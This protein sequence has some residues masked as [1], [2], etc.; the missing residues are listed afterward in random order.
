MFFLL[1][2]EKNQFMDNYCLESLSNG[3][4]TMLP[5]SAGKIRLPDNWKNHLITEF[6]QPYML[7]LKS[8]LLSEIKAGKIIFPKPTEYFN[9]FYMT[10]FSKVK[11]IILGQDPYHGPGQAHGLCFS[12]PPKI[13][14]PPSLRNIFIELEKDIGKRAPVSG[15][16]ESWARQGVLLLNSTLTVQAGRAG[17]HQNKGWEMFTD[18]VIHLLNK[19]KQQLV[20]MLWGA[21]AQRKGAFIDTNRHLVLT[22]AHPSPFSASNG[23]FGCRHFSKA[24]QYLK[25][26]G[27]AMIDW[28]TIRDKADKLIK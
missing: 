17:S 7:Q 18:R 16:L 19:E 2:I 10:S 28:N 15:C 21:Y 3:H 1:V 27:K 11:V 13:S 20:F 5:A 25:I 23:F 4:S 26:H 9:A 6:S 22:A 24:N 8:F 12:V 14:L